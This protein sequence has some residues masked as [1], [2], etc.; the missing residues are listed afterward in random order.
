[1]NQTMQAVLAAMRPGAVYTAQALRG[2]AEHALGRELPYRDVSA[3]LRGL[4]A[5]KLV[6]FEA[7]VVDRA[8][9]GTMIG[10]KWRLVPDVEQVTQ[11]AAPK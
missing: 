5:R 6:T 1:M 8:M 9:S 11:F 10:G 4:R 7:P 2:A 3:A